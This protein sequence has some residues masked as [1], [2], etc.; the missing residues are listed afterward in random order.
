MSA[1]EPPLRIPVRPGV[2]LEHVFPTLTAEQIVRVAHHG[3]ARHLT[4][5]DVL[6]EAGAA[7]V[8]FYVVTTGSLEVVRPSASSE[9]LITVH[10]PGGFTGEV[11]VLSGRRTLVLTRA[12]EDSDV[13]ELSREQLLAFVQTDQQLGEIFMRAFIL[14]RIELIAS[15]I[16]DVVLI[17]SAHSRWHPAASRSS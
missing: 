17:G 2:R 3:H 1:P 7:S 9:T 11:N 14:R 8:S 6:I 10:R 15:G 5:G 12:A 4:K 13:I 16:G